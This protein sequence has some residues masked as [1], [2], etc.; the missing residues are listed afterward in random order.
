MIEVIIQQLFTKLVHTAN[1]TMILPTVPPSIRSTVLKQVLT[2]SYL[3]FLSQPSSQ[4]FRDVGTRPKTKSTFYVNKT[5]NLDSINTDKLIKNTDKFVKNTEKFDENANKFGKNTEILNENTKNC[6]E[7]TEKCD[8]NIDKT[9]LDKKI[10]RQ[11]EYYFGDYNLP[12]D[13]FMRDLMEE[14]NGNYKFY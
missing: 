2:R 1:F 5:Q 6:V 3:S 13:R 8:E 9:D 14:E 4:V 11:I 10:I 7:N 12:K